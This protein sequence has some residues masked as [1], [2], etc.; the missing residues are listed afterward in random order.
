MTRENI[1]DGISRERDRQEGMWGVAFD[2]KNTIND[3]VTYI[4]AYASSAAMGNL[5]PRESR[6][7]ILQA[8]TIGVAAL[9]RF[10]AN[11]FLPPR[12]YDE[13]AEPDYCP[14][15]YVEKVCLACNHLGCEKVSHP[16]G[17]S[18]TMVD[19]LSCGFGHWTDDF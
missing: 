14:K 3:W 10:D 11:G 15:E 19:K 6:K 1:F 13:P 17:D 4:T 8:V 12:H 7:K 2:D 18:K 5:N 16:G 9:E